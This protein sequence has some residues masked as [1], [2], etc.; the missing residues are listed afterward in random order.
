[1]E[2]IAPPKKNRG[3]QIIFLHIHKTAGMSLRG[4]FVKNYR[5]GVHFNTGVMELDRPEWDACLD[6]LRE[7]DPGEMASYRVFKGH[8]P[9]GLH[10]ALAEPSRYIT[11]LRDPVRR[12]LSQYR[13][14]V[15]KKQLPSDHRIDP[16]RPDWNLGARPSL[17]RSLDN[18]Q[19]RVLAGA[20]LD[21]PFGG[22]TE[23]HLRLAMRNLDTHF[24]FVGLT[25]QFD[26]SLMIMLHVCGWK[27]R[28]YVPDNVTPQDAVIIPPEIVEQIRLL[29]RF[30]L[31]LYR[32]AE[33]R[34]ACLVKE[35]GWKLRAKYRVFVWGNKV[36]QLLH[37]HRQWRKARR[38]KPCR[39]EMRPLP[40]ASAILPREE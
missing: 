9:F 36:H 13:M 40:V 23:E 10:E 28:F 20:A 30:D 6:R 14:V 16:S 21:L 31:Q 37:R 27:W 4:L 33:E 12:A 17:A 22:C 8:M 5:D 38:T 3:P 39:P 24:E 2:E 19:T 34:F 35:A 29:N 11:F 26:L 7:M 32:H 1:M 18:G 25:E 15:R